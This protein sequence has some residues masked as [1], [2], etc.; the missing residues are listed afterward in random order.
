MRY[1]IV[2]ADDLG[3]S[4]GTTRGILEAHT[5]GILTS[6]S[7]MVDTPWS[8]EAAALA[9]LEPR[10]SVGLHVDLG[11]EAGNGAGDAG[12]HPDEAI[13]AALHR[14]LDRF[15]LLMGAPPSHLDSHHD[16]HRRPGLLECF[17]EFASQCGLP[18]RGHSPVRT[19]S[20]FYGQWGGESHPE[21][22]GVESL[23][24]MLEREIGDGVTE[25]SCHPGYRDARLATSYAAEREVELRTLC[26]PR[27]RE[28]LRS[29]DITLA[30]FHDLGTLGVLDA[31]RRAP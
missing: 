11:S 31:A 17:R 5:G 10:L 25:L 23:L 26:D 19:F 1:L 28:G 27:V 9:T 20:R 15:V 30:S 16:V 21:H 29:L 7:L 14:Q 3:A 12:G 6:A 24:R 2:N 13:R 18:L 22:V 4:P 8:V